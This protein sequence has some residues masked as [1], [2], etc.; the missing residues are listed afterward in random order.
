VPI[1]I[2]IILSLPLQWTE[3]GLFEKKNDELMSFLI[4]IQ[5]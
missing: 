4:Q 3:M 1:A 2:P 5:H